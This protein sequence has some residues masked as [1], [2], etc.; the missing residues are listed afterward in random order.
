MYGFF[1]GWP[2]SRELRKE[3]E[4]LSYILLLKW[5]TRFSVQNKQNVLFNM[6]DKVR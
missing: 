4:S 5:N 3:V 2:Q 6:E 1:G